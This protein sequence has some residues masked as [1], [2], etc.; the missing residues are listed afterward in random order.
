MS[1]AAQSVQQL[2]QVLRAL[3]RGLRPES[4]VAP[5]ELQS[6]VAVATEHLAALQ[7]VADAPV[8]NVVSKVLSPSRAK[9]LTREL[10]EA[11]LFCSTPNLPHIC[12]QGQEPDH[13]PPYQPGP[14]GESFQDTTTRIQD[15]G[16]DCYLKGQ[17]HAP[18]IDA[19]G[20]TEW[21]LVPKEADIAMLQS[22]FSDISLSAAHSTYGVQDSVWYSM[23]EV[24][25]PPPLDLLSFSPSSDSA[26]SEHPIHTN[27]TTLRRVY[28]A[29]SGYPFDDAYYRDTVAPTLGL[30]RGLLARPRSEPPMP[31]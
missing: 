29:L 10:G 27:S 2:Q 11:L 31:Q 1:A 3:D 23:L 6:L 16:F 18:L 9:T 20:S 25:P 15:F 28:A 30:L 13:L 24:A 26:F 17:Q 21:Q 12:I 7:E 4:D 19:A 22:A 8:L 5:E 14:V